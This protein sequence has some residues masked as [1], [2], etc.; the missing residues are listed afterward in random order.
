MTD[1][2]S[3]ITSR[4]RRR[5]GLDY[6][7]LWG[8]ILLGVIGVIMVYSATREQLMNAGYNPHYYLERQGVFVGPRRDRD[9]RDLAHRLSASRDRRDAASTSCRC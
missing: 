6:S 8:M 9:V 3:A 1:T 4:L 7:L 2:L 5:E